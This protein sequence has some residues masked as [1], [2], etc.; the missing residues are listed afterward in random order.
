MIFQQP[1]LTLNP[2]YTVGEHIAETVRR[3]RGAS[4]RDAWARAVEMLERV[5]IPNA[6]QRAKDYPHMFS[7]G[8]CQRVMIAQALA[9]E[10][11]LLIADEPTTALDVTIQASV[12]ELLRELEEETGIAVLLITHDL[13]VIAEMADRVVV[14]YAGQVVE[15][16]DAED[17]LA[18]PRNPY[19]E[20]LLSAV[21]TE[22]TER[23]AT[24]PGSIPVPGHMP[25]GCR[26]APRCAHAVF[27][28]C[29]ASEPALESVGSSRV[30]RCIRTRELY[31]VEAEASSR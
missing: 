1:I 11:D 15:G 6:A 30:S 14:M 24:V 17:V 8:M 7:G 26:F 9:C 13:G 18:R 20:A 3:H 19:T 16:G 27:G 12:L 23:L 2:A 31:V 4:R 22:T 21:P 25:A 29:D 5:R 28:R 10:P